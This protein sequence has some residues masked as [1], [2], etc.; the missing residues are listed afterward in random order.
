MFVCLSRSHVIRFRCLCARGYVLLECND[1]RCLRN[2]FIYSPILMKFSQSFDIICLQINAK[3]QNYTLRN[4]WARRL[5]SYNAILLG[6]GEGGVASKKLWWH[7]LYIAS[8]NLQAKIGVPRCHS[9]RDIRKKPLFFPRYVWFYA[10]C[11]RMGRGIEKKKDSCIDWLNMWS[12][13]TKTDIV[14]LTISEFCLFIRTD[15][16]TDGQ[17]DGQTDMAQSTRL[18]MLIKNIYTL[19]GL[20]RLLLP[21]TYFWQTHYT[22]QRV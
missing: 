1:F 11:G 2:F 6:V 3:L 9:Y 22:P 4:K 18:V 7:C 15:R 17:T 12:I 5:Q 16:R 13:L 8:S 20:P 10:Y 21:V 19:W 14:A